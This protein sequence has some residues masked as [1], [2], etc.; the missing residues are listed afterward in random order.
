MGV[1][2]VLR[3][4]KPEAEQAIAA[5]APAGRAPVPNGAALVLID[6]GKSHAKIVLLMLADELRVRLPEI[7]HV[8]VFSKAS[9]AVT[10]TD[11]EAR[12]LA[13]RATLVV[14]GLG[15][16][17]AC[18]SCSVLD[19]ITFEKLGVPATAVI[20]EPFAPLVEKFAITMGMPGYHNVTLP[21]PVATRSDDEVRGLV[22]G[23]ADEV[24]RQLTGAVAQR[25][26]S[27]VA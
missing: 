26:L 25:E 16:C 15:D 13:E 7:E 10:V 27:R 21:H 4:D 19:A 9:A 24:V 17:G 5:S 14:T 8:E 2:T 23:L 20:T 3:P 6:N 1:I 18:S 11:D 12:R 22:A